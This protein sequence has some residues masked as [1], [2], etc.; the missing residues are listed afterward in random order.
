MT[1][2]R[3]STPL[4]FVLVTAACLS[5]FLTACRTTPSADVKPLSSFDDQVQDLLTEMTLEEKIGQM[6]QLDQEHLKD[7]QDIATYTIGSVLSG[8]SSDPKAGN[9]LQHWTDM[10]DSYQKQALSTR[11]GI[12]IL[13]GVDAVHGHNNVLNAV[14]FPHNIGM[15][16]TR[17]PQLVREMSRITAL[18][19]R[20]TGVQWTFAPCVTVPRDDRWGRTYEGFSEDPAIVAVLGEAAVQG[21][22]G[23]ELANPLS[24]AACAKHYIA[25]GGTT[26]QILEEEAAKDGET[27]NNY[28]G[29][30]D[31]GQR[32]YRVK[33]DQGNTEIDEAGLR[34]IHLP[35]YIDAVN[36]GV[37]TIMPSY[38]SWNGLKCS[39][40]KYLM[41]DVLKEELGFDGFLISDYRAIDQV[42][43]D[44][45]TAIGISINAGMDMGMIPSKYKEF[46]QNLKE[47]VTEGVVP[48][49]RIDDA[50]TRILRVKCAMGMLDK[51]RSQ[52]AD[53]DL[54]DS[55]GAGEN[56]QVARQA[57]RESLV[58][59]K[60][61][62]SALP[63]SKK[64]KRIH[65]AGDSA[66]NIGNQCG[67][68]TI[69]WQ[70]KTGE[71][72][73]GGT[74]ILEAIQNAV[75]ADTEVTYS[76]DGT[77]ATGADVVV[78]VVGEKPYA[79]GFGDSA[80]LTLSTEEK[81][82]V[83]NAKKAGLPLVVILFSG[84][85]LVVPDIMAQA[86]AFV[87][88]WLPGTEG[89]GIADILFGDFKPQGKLSFS[90]P[91][92]GDQ[93]P[94][95]AG[96]EDYAPLFELGFGLSY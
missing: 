13:Y 72:T 92:S 4:G 47:L 75:S 33:L 39:A 55:F 89:Q 31:T 36:A 22:Q 85:P 79:E 76:K 43:P 25:D 24:V 10:Y 93:H 20:A 87:A 14:V 21:F 77:G 48:M 27:S 3:H 60:N 38:S 82:V 19:M 80:D 41:T 73:T 9:S 65:V 86:D 44:Y 34:A 46:F 12:P 71:V 57:V 52:L 49:S 23:Q 6:I 84:R 28:G 32:G 91:K 7:P 37:A 64:S 78:V 67:G 11:L 26:A 35:P 81:A 50:V 15:G 69:D 61:F 1:R 70:G 5:I 30:G 56:R 90:W 45:K 54:W 42:H 74:T 83:A 96:D 40:N 95:N 94:L 88:A 63:L 62:N 17:N 53:R 51:D 16:C 18:E 29:E 58:L 68:W 66:H 59:L 2:H 8:G